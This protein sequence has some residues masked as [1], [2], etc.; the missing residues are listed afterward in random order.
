MAQAVAEADVHTGQ[1]VCLED[2]KAK[3]DLCTESKADKDTDVD[4]LPKRKKPKL[5]DEEELEI[6]GVEHKVSNSAEALLFVIV[7]VDVVDVVS[8][9][10]WLT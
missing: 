7:V 8:W 2:S 4:A 6:C 1:M 5:Q 3:A 10:T 9:L